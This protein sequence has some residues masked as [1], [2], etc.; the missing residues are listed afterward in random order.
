[1]VEGDINTKK[2]GLLKFIVVLMAV[3][4]LLGTATLFGLVVYKVKHGVKLNPTAAAAS[5]A[6]SADCKGGNFKIA[7][8]GD[9]VG[10]S[11]DGPQ[12]LLMFAKGT[13]KEIV[14]FNHCTGQVISRLHT[15]Q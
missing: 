6:P 13:T 3:V 5:A 8:P 1:M 10:A 12:A 2:L 4:L 15:G 7:S 11:V 14:I 9:L